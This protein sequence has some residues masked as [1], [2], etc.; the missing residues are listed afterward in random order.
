MAPRLLILVILSYRAVLIHHKA[1]CSVHS[2][3][4]SRHQKRTYLSTYLPTFPTSQKHLK[5][6]TSNGPLGDSLCIQPSRV[7][8][9]PTPSPLTPPP[10]FATRDGRRRNPHS[11]PSGCSLSTPSKSAPFL[12]KFSQT[13]TTYIQIFLYILVY[14][15]LL[16]LT[17]RQRPSSSAPSQLMRHSKTVR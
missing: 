8:R 5:S 11:T 17:L 1:P 4:Q 10:N 3:N 2:L 9:P 6:S 16:V 12:L 14:I 15:P 7:S 13:K